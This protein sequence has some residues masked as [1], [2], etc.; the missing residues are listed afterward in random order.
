ML[1][2]PGKEY[3]IMED[4]AAFVLSAWI[5]PDKFN[6]WSPINKGLCQGS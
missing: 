1:G 3:F 2:T 5:A 4:S 6:M